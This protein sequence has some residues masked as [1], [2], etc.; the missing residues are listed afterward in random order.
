MFHNTTWAQLTSFNKSTLNI[1]P[2]RLWPEHKNTKG[3]L[4]NAEIRKEVK[5]MENI[6][7]LYTSNFNFQVEI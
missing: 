1:A 2:P 7:P 6:Q 3:Q 5:K 4:N